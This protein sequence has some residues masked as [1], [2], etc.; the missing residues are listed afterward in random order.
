MSKAESLIWVLLASAVLVYGNGRHDLITVVLHHPSV[1]R[2]GYYLG[3]AGLCVNMLVF[4]HLAIWGPLLSSPKEPVSNITHKSPIAIHIGT[5]A[6]LSAS[7]GFLTAL[8]PVWSWLT[9]LILFVLF[10]GFIMGV[11]LLPSSQSRESVKA[12]GG[13]HVQTLKEQ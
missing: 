7:I 13:A 2:K 4:L 12:S 9:P 10:M 3:I 1:W 6:G 5:A 11:Q 8:W